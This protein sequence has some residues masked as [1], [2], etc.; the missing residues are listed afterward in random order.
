MQL[1]ALLLGRGNNAP[2]PGKKF[3]L[4]MVDSIDLRSKAPSAGALRILPP[5]ETKKQQQNAVR[6]FDRI[7]ET[8]YTAE[9][10]KKLS[11]SNLMGRYR[12]ALTAA[13]GTEWLARN[14]KMRREIAVWELNKGRA[15]HNDMTRAETRALNVV[16]QLARFHGEE[17]AEDDE[18]GEE[19]F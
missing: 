18:D 12:D 4:G 6:I 8:Y 11:L 15:F 3:F 19:D 10:E 2:A 1:S 16:V 13:Y 14:W 5:S 7:K 9:D 17:D